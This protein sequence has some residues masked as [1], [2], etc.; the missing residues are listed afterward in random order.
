[1]AFNLKSKKI[2]IV[3]DFPGMRKTVREMLYTL[4]AVDLEEV[5]NGMSAIT[6][7]QKNHFDIVLCDYNLGAG[8]NGLQV[9]EEAKVR[10]LLPFSAIFIMITA[11][12][13]PGMVLG[14]MESKPDE[15]LTKPFT[16]RQLLSRIERNTQ[17]KNYLADIEKEKTNN[18]FPKAILHCEEL[19]KSGDRKMHSQLVKLRAELA[20][21]IGDFNYAKTLYEEVLQ[22][23]ALNW[24]ETGLGKIHVLKGNTDQ[25]ITTLKQVIENNPMMMEAYDWLAQAYLASKQNSDAEEILTSAVNFSPQ[26][27]L[28]QQKLASVAE[29]AGN[30]EVASKAYR[31]AIE[32]GKHSIYKTSIDY[33]GLAKLYNENDASSDAL[34]IIALL[35]EEFINDPESELRATILETAVFHTME[36][37][38]SA[39]QAFQRAKILSKQPNIPKEL[40]LEMVAACYQNNESALAEQIVERLVK[41]YID[42]DYF[43]DAIKTT[44][45]KAGK[46]DHAELLINKISQELSKIN[47]RGVSLYKKGK[48][49]EAIQVLELALEKMPNNKTIILN[50]TKILLHEFRASGYNKE[51]L[52]RIQ[53]YI[54]RAIELG[55]EQ[56]KIGNIKLEYNKIMQH[57]QSSNRHAQ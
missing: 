39:E 49:S 9:L 52:N 16:T 48:N 47:N 45:N 34:R 17:R 10:K 54:N 51:K 20:I 19:L 21:D 50:I 15:Y 3:D 14:A 27:I 8:K 42:D 37:T 11:E 23:R 33:A 6:A 28:R 55:T 7:M 26:A 1:M 32:L 53:S 56:H 30:V 43:I 29:T 24:A 18:N 22:N 40:Q 12:Q 4:D 44:L 36:N 25:A 31:A 2:L 5:N 13:T 57:F 41:N 46:E 38:D 35:R